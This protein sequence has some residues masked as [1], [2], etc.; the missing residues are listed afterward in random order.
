M[1]DKHTSDSALDYI[2]DSPF[3]RGEQQ[4]Q[5]RLGVREQMER[6]GRRVIRDYMPD[7]H[8][9]FYA[10]LPYV[11][12]GHADA[13]G[14]PWA[15]VLFGKPGFIRSPHEKAL[16]ITASPLPGDPLAKSWREGAHIGL[17]GIELPTRRRNR[18]ATVVRASEGETLQLEIGQSFGNCPQYI[19][20]R[21]LSW[22]N[23]EAQPSPKVESLGS[24]STEH[25]QL[26]AQSDTFFV[27]SYLAANRG[28]AS[29]GADVSHRGGKPGFVRV[30]NDTTLTIPDYLG[31]NHFNT[32]GNIEENGRAGLLF[33]D[34][35]NGHMLT[36]SGRAE[37]LWDADDLHYF[38]GAQRLWRFH[39]NEGYFVRNALPVR[40]SLDEFSPNSLL[41]GTW[42]EAEAARTLATQQQDWRPLRVHRIEEE[43]ATIRSVYL[44]PEGG[45]A[46]YR[47]EPG[48]FLSL[49][50][51]IQGETVVRTYSLS[52]APAEA[53]Y[54]ISVKREV[55]DDAANPDGVFSN[56]LHDQLNTGDVLEARAPAGTF[57][58]D[59][60]E[61]RPA[62]LLAAGVGITPMISMMRHTLFEGIRTRHMRP[63]TLFAAARSAHERAFYEELKTLQQQSGG[64]LR[65]VWTLSQVDETLKPGIDYQH[66]GRLSAELLQEV[67]PL[68]DYDFY[69]CGP[70]GFMQ[71][72]YDL[73][74]DLGVQDQRIMAEE[75]GPASLKRKQD[76]ASKPFVPQAVAREALV[77]F[78]ASGF[79][80]AWTEQDG[81]LL[82]L[83][84]AHGLSPDFACRSGQC[85]AC[86]VTLLA[87]TVS[88]ESECTFPVADNEVLLCCAKPAADDSALPSVSLDI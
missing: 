2:A 41:T 42:Q 28:A 79:E 55:S 65:T 16:Q 36:L 33:L 88:Y 17:L 38:E 18:L 49:R 77:K 51:D 31:N 58:Y 24:F 57:R 23:K 27:A 14:W 80:Q 12:L 7:Q 8:R 25:A 43:S 13:Q 45:G 83:A 29:E 70:P 81:S 82:E 4:I 35:E 46:R 32:F 37:I 26:I 56:F 67:L 1:R 53:G 75:F 60:G 87:G 61:S 71:H 47:F 69:L 59:A 44:Q 21:S 72:C 22:L 19:Q 34:F 68:D 20:T 78:S 15:S 73:L 6:F 5:H 3:H 63:V 11:F 54:R 62:V 52:S 66:V 40:W 74:R 9:H 50:A 10:Q 86:K 85:G 39:L 30:D 64:Q 84:E 48:Q 76:Q